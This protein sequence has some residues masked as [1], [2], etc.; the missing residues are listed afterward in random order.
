[1]QPIIL[2]L[3]ILMS[4]PSSSEESESDEDEDWSRSPCTGI[5]CNKELLSP[6]RNFYHLWGTFFTCEEESFW[7]RNSHLLHSHRCLHESLAAQRSEGCCQQNLTRL[8][9]LQSWFYFLAGFPIQPGEESTGQRVAFALQYCAHRSMSSPAGRP[10]ESFESV[11]KTFSPTFPKSA[12]YTSR[13]RFWG[14]V[15]STIIF[16]VKFQIGFWETF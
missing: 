1:M 14:V 2:L 15:S 3:R 8:A 5:T 16:A 11:V 9:I 4:W 13:R 10:K 12:S 7:W 6:A